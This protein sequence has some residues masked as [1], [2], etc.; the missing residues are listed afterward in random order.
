MELL[1]ENQK[2]LIF[3]KWIFFPMTSWFVK[4]LEFRWLNT[5]KVDL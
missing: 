5:L 3:F 4:L 1:I 2:I